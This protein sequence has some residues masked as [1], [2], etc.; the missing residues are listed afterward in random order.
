MSES[1]NTLF[2]RLSGPMQSWG[3]ASR[4]Q[5]RR[6][7]GYPSKSGV[8]GVLLCAMGVDRADAPSAL[9]PLV[10]LEMG[11]RVDRQGVLDWDY[12]TA[13][14]G[15]GIRQAKGGIKYTASTKEPETLLSRRQYIFDASF[16]AVLWGDAGTVESCRLALASPVWPVFLGRKCC[17]PSEPIFAGV[18]SYEGPKDALASQPWMAGGLSFGEGERI[19][20]GAYIEH[21]PGT[22][23]P[24]NAVLVHDVPRTL[25]HPS[26]GP[27]W[28]IPDT[29]RVPM[30]SPAV[31]AAT[32]A[33]RRRVDYASPQWKTIRLERLTH[34]N[35]LCVLCKSPAVEVH[36]VTYENV[37]HEKVEDL[38]SVCNN[39]HDACTQLEYGRDLRLHRVD[40][41]DPK[42]RDTILRQVK[43]L[44]TGRRLGRRRRIMESARAFTTDFFTDSPGAVTPQG[45]GG[46]T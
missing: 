43:K 14:A 19:P 22:R 15:Y 32:S 31:V 11:V 40:P 7:D 12:H 39:C 21:R 28:V 16:L 38:R 17:V 1:A 42:Q 20:L 18:G 2:L 23:P 30:V 46:N 36:H 34:D 33:G 5:L 9:E 27:R 45:V 3:T 8:L 29:V 41:A 26:H 24:E 37:G 25:L 44:I 6:T 4:L 35:E 10:K 13:G